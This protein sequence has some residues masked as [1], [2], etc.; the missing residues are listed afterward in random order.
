MANT[1]R[2]NR[3]KTGRRAPRELI[4]V[5]IDIVHLRFFLPVVKDGDPTKFIAHALKMLKPNGWIQWTEQ[6]LATARV[7][8]AFA[9]A[10]TQH[11]DELFQFAIATLEPRYAPSDSAI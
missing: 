4:F 8:K 1:V 7:A 6:D 3:S 10:E 11:T 2:F 5:P 9:E